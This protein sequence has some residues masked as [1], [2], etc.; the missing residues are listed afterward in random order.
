ME[1]VARSNAN[2]NENRR[3]KETNLAHI[4]LLI[5]AVIRTCSGRTTQSTAFYFRL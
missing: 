2:F 1:T 5:D 4:S 3:E